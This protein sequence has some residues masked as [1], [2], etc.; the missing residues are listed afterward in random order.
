MKSEPKSR[1]MELNP[2]LRRTVMNP[3]PEQKKKENQGNLQPLCVPGPNRC[4]LR[5]FARRSKTK[6]TCSPSA[7]LVRIDATSVDS[8]R[9]E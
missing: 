9:K 4:H 8:Q 2:R 6:E 1:I 5:R 7:F 3:N